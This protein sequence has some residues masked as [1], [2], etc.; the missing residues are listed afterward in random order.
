MQ[1]ILDHTAFQQK[2]KR[3]AHQ[4]IENIHE[5]PNVFFGAIHGNGY[6]MAKSLHEEIC[7][8]LPGDF[9]LFKIEVNKEE[10]WSE[11]IKLS[12]PIEDLKNGYIV[13]IDDVLNSGKT[14]Q[15]VLVKFLEQPTKAIKTVAMVDRK[16]R[17]FPIKADFVGLS[18]STTLQ[19]RVEVFTKND[20]FEAYLV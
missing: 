8:H 15:Y 17:R 16:H 2:L 1:R 4:I 6:E 7:S 19:N 3:L 14:M 13:L 9:P 12:M 5:E 11:E 10:P 18:L 20:E